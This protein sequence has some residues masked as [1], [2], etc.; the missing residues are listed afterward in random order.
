MVMGDFRSF[1]S[2]KRG[3]AMPMQPVVDPAGWSPDELRDVGRWSYRI[4]EREADELAAGV[5]AVR[6]DGV[7]IV[8][9]ARENFPLGGFADVLADVRRELTDG[10]GIV[11]LQNFPVERFDREATAIAY[12]GLGAYLGRT[13]SQNKQGHVLG[14]VKDLGGDYADPHTRGYM[15]RAEM[16]FH[17]DACD[18]VG[19]LCLQASRQG[20]ASRVAS[21][22]TVY[23]RILER[24]PDLAEVLTQDFYRSRSGETNAGD[25]PYFKQPIFSFTDGYFSATGAGAVIDKAQDLP[26]VPKFTALQKEAVEVYRATVEECALDIDFKPG[27]I[28]FLNNFVMLHTRR[29]YEDWPE[30]ARKRHLLRLWLSDPVGRPIPQEQRQGRAGRG[31]RLAGVRLVAP[32]DVEAVA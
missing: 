31:V 10:R 17:A 6:R 1:Q 24:R 15:T 12:I 25:A 19:L 27:D 20:G 18:Y 16:R 23:N 32:L 8:E 4:G 5:A 9:V 2:G 11:M 14:H 30:P 26:G 7:P 29:E 22:V 21:S 3:V 28:Q 13:M